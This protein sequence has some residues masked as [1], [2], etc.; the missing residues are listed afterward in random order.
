MLLIIRVPIVA[1]R[2]NG[3]NA[4]VLQYFMDHRD[5]KLVTD[6]QKLKPKLNRA[7][8]TENVRHTW[9]TFMLQ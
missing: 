5:I 4:T 7:Y 3:H 8:V 2:R 1:N 9:T 6:K